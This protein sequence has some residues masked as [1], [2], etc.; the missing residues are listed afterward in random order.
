MRHTFLHLLF[1]LV[2]CLSCTAVASAANPFN[3]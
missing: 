2:L 1:V 3:L